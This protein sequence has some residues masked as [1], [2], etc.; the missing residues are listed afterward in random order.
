MRYYGGMDIGASA[1]KLAI[2]DENRRIVAKAVRRSG[3]DYAQTAA[4][5]L[6]EALARA[7]LQRDQLTAAFS[8]GYGRDNVPWVDGRMTE[9]ACHGRGAHFH[10]PGRITVIDIGAQDSKVIHLDASGRR[11]GFKM[12]RKCAAGTGAF[13]EEIAY[14][15]H[16]PL[17]KL[18]ELAERSDGEVTLGSF[19][20]VFAATEILE[21]IRAG[22]KVEDIVKGAF[23]SVAKRI[24]EMD[25][26][27]GAM[28]LT[29]GV[30]AHNRV[31]ADLLA[32]S[33]AT[34]AKVPPDPQ[35]TGAF[36][37]ALFA[38]EHHDKGE[39][40]CS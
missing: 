11:T 20:T 18:N 35:L 7:N 15:L 37:A 36:G 27:Q 17:E 30:V 10:F 31:L 9:I 26:V 12:N 32:E 22:V 25:T 38:M 14:R 24:L 6:D 4:E 23:R 39:G 40:R 33:F 29:G 21:K 19:C 16:L 1:A 13:I 28:V 5:C 34:E 2:V 8:T 3:V